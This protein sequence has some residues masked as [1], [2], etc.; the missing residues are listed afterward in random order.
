MRA[1]LQRR[2]AQGEGR[3]RIVCSAAATLLAA[4]SLLS[5]P[6][7]LLGGSPAQRESDQEVAGS[8][9]PATVVH[10][11]VFLKDGTPAVE[12]I[13]TDPVKPKISK[14]AEPMRLVIDLPNTNMSVPRKLVPVKSQDVGAI[15]LELSATDPPQVHVEIDLLKPLDYTWESAGNRLLVQLHPI[16]AKSPPGPP[17]IAAADYSNVVPVDRVPSGSSVT[18]LSDTTVMRLRRGGDFYV[19]PRTTVSVNRSRNGPDL[20]LAMGVGALETHIMLGNS[21]DEVVT[22]DFRILLRGPGE[23]DYAIRA[24]PQGNTCV[25]T[26]PGN[27]SQAIIYELMGDGKY[28]FQP[29]DQ[30]VFHAGRLRSEDTA[31]HGASLDG[32]ETILPVECGCPPPPQPSV[33]LASG[34]GVGEGADAS[35]QGTSSASV[36]EPSS[37]P[38]ETERSLEATTGAKLPDAGVEVAEPPAWQRNLPPAK[39]EATLTFT[40]SA[41]VLAEALP[42]S[43]RPAPIPMAALPPPL[44]T[45]E[46]APV[47][48][49]RFEGVRHFFAR[50]FG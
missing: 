4:I 48:H 49:K 31:F 50:I 3:S 6:M 9:S 8:Q 35:A 21:T 19:C 25:K 38:P 28:E 11:N 44:P 22:P 7:Q 14:L 26:L 29:R 5:S 33:L 15:R 2:H 42:V 39:A 27:T 32:N 13:T 24:D 41:R 46:R 12:I 43:T 47:K 30:I 34:A 10:F 1:R 37:A 17:P 20:M 16:V 45:Q 40:P 18:A 23:F 36:K